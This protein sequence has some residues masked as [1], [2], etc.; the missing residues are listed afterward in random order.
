MHRRPQNVP[1]LDELEEA[2]D[3]ACL[4]ACMLAEAADEADEESPEDAAA[5]AAIAF[6]AG[7]TSR[8]ALLEWNQVHGH[9]MIMRN[10]HQHLQLLLLF[11][12][13]PRQETVQNPKSACAPMYSMARSGLAACIASLCKIL[14]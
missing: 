1:E 2:A 7:S 9:Q 10:R 3:W 14:L 6:C 11:L 13:L 12:M 5:A 4:A 8:R